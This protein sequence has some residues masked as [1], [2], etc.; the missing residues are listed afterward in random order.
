MDLMTPSRSTSAIFDFPGFDTDGTGLTPF[1]R[2]LGVGR[3]LRYKQLRPQKQTANEVRYWDLCWKCPP[4]LPSYGAGLL[5]RPVRQ[6]MVDGPQCDRVRRERR[7]DPGRGREK[8][9]PG[10]HDVSDLVR[11]AI[12]VG[13]RRVRVLAHDR[14]AHEVLVDERARPHFSCRRGRDDRLSD[15]RGVAIERALV[16]AKGHRHPR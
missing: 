8:R 7:I 5:R 2:M 3:M 1:V 11:D 15:R 10:D 9:I 13:H 14:P 6:D 12:A 16:I 4:K